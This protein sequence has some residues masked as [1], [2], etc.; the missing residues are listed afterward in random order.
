MDIFWKYTFCQIMLMQ[1]KK[2]FLVNKRPCV[3][4]FSDQNRAKTIPFRAAHTS[5]PIRNQDFDQLFIL[6]VDEWALDNWS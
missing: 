6:N 3:K 2:Q 4:P 5:S 1:R